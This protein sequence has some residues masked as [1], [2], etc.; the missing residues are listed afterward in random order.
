MRCK[1]ARAWPGFVQRRLLNSHMRIALARSS[2]TV[3]TDDS[4]VESDCSGLSAAD[5]AGKI[6][7]DAADF[8]AVPFDNSSEIPTPD[9][10]VAE[11]RSSLDGKNCLMLDKGSS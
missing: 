3:D 4:E 7:N 8:G 1:R 11:S 2:L 5:V 6:E 9:I 10:F